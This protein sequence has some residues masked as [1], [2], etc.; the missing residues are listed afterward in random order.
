LLET[1][2]PDNLQAS[3]KYEEEM[4]PKLLLGNVME[5]ET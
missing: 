5:I 4:H 3:K 1:I 2:K